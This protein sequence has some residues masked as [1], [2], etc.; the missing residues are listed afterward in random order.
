MTKEVKAQNLD[1]DLW[2]AIGFTERAL[3]RSVMF[4]ASAAQREW[5]RLAEGQL[6]GTLQAYKQALADGGIETPGGP[7]AIVVLANSPRIAGMLELGYPPFDMRTTLLQAGAPGVKTSAKGSRYRAIPFRHKTPSA[8]P[9][10][11]GQDLPAGR[12][13]SGWMHGAGATNAPGSMGGVSM[14][15]RMANA[16]AMSA[17]R[18]ATPRMPQVANPVTP[19]EADA[20]LGATGVNRQEG[21]ELGRAIH[22][23]AKQ[24]QPSYMQNNGKMYWGDQVLPGT[25]GAQKLREWHK[26]DIYAGMY[27]IEKTYENATQYQYKTFRMISTNPNADPR[28]WQHPGFKALRL[29]DQVA[30][31]VVRT[32]PDMIQAQFGGG[33][34]G[35]DGGE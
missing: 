6:S 1:T 26:T 4:M 23:A 30:Q 3:T 16:F 11:D 28:S 14:S 18:M 7:R 33:A 32:W 34:A 10:A 31:Y 35:G 27:R 9:P 15:P 8:K 21:W 20:P 19:F 22:E 29:V 5:R 2:A 13:G 25:A 12:M 17:P 24:V